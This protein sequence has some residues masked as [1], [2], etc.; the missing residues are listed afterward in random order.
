MSHC[1]CSH[2]SKQH[3]IFIISQWS[4]HTEN[5]SLINLGYV[6]MIGDVGG[7]DSGRSGSSNAFGII[8]VN[9]HKGDCLRTSQPEE[10]GVPLRQVPNQNVTTQS[11][12]LCCP[13]CWVCWWSQIRPLNVTSVRR[14]VINWST[15]FPHA[16]FHANSVFLLIFNYYDR[17]W[18]A[19]CKH[20]WLLYR[21]TI[22]PW[23]RVVVTHMDMDRAREG[24]PMEYCTMYNNRQCACISLLICA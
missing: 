7:G 18:V 14:V 2:R 9:P 15:I 5:K 3:Q 12:Q 4:V 23:S 20:G 13:G 16:A 17:K 19:W 8:L 22:D 21:L 6:S 10:R 1:I 24:P 11:S